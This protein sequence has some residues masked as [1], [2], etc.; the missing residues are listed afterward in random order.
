MTDW[1]AKNRASTP[2]AWDPFPISLRI[3]NWLKFLQSADIGQKELEVIT[4]SLKEQ[5]LWL[6]NHLEFHLM[7]NHLF[8][9]GK[10]LMFMGLSFQGKDAKR[11]LSK[12]QKIIETQLAEQ[13]LKD[14]GHF[15][16]STMYHSMIFEDC[17]DLLNIMLCANKPGLGCL[18]KKITDKSGKMAGYLSLMLLSDGRISLF[19]D[20]AF[21]IEAEPQDILT[22]Y[23]QIS[24]NKVAAFK[25]KVCALP[26]TGYYILCPSK[27]DKMIIDCGMIGPDYQPGHSHCDTLSFEFSVKGQRIIVDSGCTGY[28]E[29]EI[30]NYNRG[31]KGH[32]TLT[33][34]EENQ[35]EIWASHRCALK[36]KPLNPVCGLLKKN[37]LFFRG[38]HDGYKRLKGSPVHSREVTCKDSVWVIKD[39]VDGRGVHFIQSRLHINPFVDIKIKNNEAQISCNKDMLLKITLVNYGIIE[40]KKGEQ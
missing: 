39:F 11:W 35:S 31:N 25:D 12:G 10:A 40:K 16:R 38:G 18:I 6:E 27:R 30:R 20:A 34:D 33:I 26:E 9:N 5:C 2:D 13:I 28:E 8:K 14:G 24:K 37:T 15:E 32:N 4:Q 23:K 22:Y 36:A 19:N 29:N 17:L 1:I 7:G 3:V 21:G